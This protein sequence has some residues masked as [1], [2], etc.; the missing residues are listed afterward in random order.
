VLAFS[1]YIKP[2]TLCTD[3]SGIG[4]GSALMQLYTRGKLRTIAYASCKL[5]NA[6]TRF[7]VTHLEAY[8]VVWSPKTS[9]SII[10]GLEITIY[11]DHQAVTELFKGNILSGRLV[12][13]YLTIQEFRPTFYYLPRRA[14]VVADVLSRNIS[15]YSVI[16]TPPLTL[17][18]LKEEQ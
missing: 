14:N 6:E 10:F 11:T 4:L 7:S 8:A 18:K 2:F 13:W 1:D 9:R 5:R 17:S 15:L 3:A 12:K 16:T